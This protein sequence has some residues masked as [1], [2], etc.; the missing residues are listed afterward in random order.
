M[1]HST[2]MIG[3]ASTLLAPLVLIVAACQATFPAAGS[4]SGSG[5]IALPTEQPQALPPGASLM[6]AGIG[7][8]AVIHGDPADPHVTWLIAQPGARL[9]TRWPPGY[10]AQFNPM[11]EVL[12]AT[13]AVVLR[14]GDHVNGGWETSGQDVLLLVP[15]F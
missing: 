7:I 11:L 4:R 12:D 8:S 1:K 10:Q 15:P 6:C 3:A 9:E 13:G 2:P 14:E 5:L